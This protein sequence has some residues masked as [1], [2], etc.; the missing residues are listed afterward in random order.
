[1]LKPVGFARASGLIVAKDMRLEWRTLETLATSFVFSLIVLSRMV[2]SEIL[3]MPA[4]PPYVFA[5][6][7]SR[8]TV[9][10][11]TSPAS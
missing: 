4:P 1:M 2:R 6:L 5:L 7:L 11:R 10:S 3:Y 8:T 9:S